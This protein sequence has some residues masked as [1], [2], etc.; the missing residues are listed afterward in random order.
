MRRAAMIVG[1]E[2]SFCSRVYKTR[3][4]NMRCRLLYIDKPKYK[5]RFGVILF[6]THHVWNFRYRVQQ[7]GN[8]PI[9]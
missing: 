3:S 7:F 6:N 5:T 9:P 2:M 4:V 1:S 8:T